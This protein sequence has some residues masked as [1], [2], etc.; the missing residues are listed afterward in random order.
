MRSNVCTVCGELF[1]IL[2]ENST[3]LGV[4][5]AFIHPTACV[6]TSLFLFSN[7]EKISDMTEPRI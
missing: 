4:T 2:G 1:S 6:L 7:R 3:V 5:F